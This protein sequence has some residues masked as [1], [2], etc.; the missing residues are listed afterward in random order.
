M[1]SK[2]IMAGR[3]PSFE[4]PGR[5]F[6]D[7]DGHMGRADAAGGEVAPGRA[8]ISGEDEDGHG[9]DIQGE[10]NVL[11]FIADHVA[12]PELEVELAGRLDGQAGAGLPAGAFGADRWPRNMGTVVKA[13]ERG[14]TAGECFQEP[15]VERAEVFLVEVAAADPGLV[16]DNHGRE[17][18][19]AQET[20]GLKRPG[21][22]VDLTK[23]AGI[24]DVFAEGAVAVEE[25]GPACFHEMRSPV[26]KT[27][28]YGD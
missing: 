26:A 6:E 3:P 22:D 12:L 19:P 18:G 5:G 4:N 13:V 16:G 17:A 1:S 9:S 14:A 27:S 8:S 23:F 10:Q 11:N 25:Y 7:P 2:R 21:V 28:E 24:A 20:D 15:G